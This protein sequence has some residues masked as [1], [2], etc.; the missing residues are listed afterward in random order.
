MLPGL[1]IGLHDD[2]TGAHDQKKSADPLPPPGFIDAG[3][4]KRIHDSLRAG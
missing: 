3:F 1:R 2:K 4:G